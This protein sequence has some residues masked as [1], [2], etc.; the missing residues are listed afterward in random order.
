MDA[1]A[2]WGM[3]VLLAGAVALGA[4]RVGSLRTSGA[5][6]AFAI[7]ALALRAAWSWGAFLIGWFVL[8]SVL[9]RIGRARKTERTRRI[10]EKGDQRDAWQVLANGGVFAL[11]AFGAVVNSAA[12]PVLGA[13]LGEELRAYAPSMQTT[14]ATLAAGALIAAGADTW[15]TEVGTLWGGTPWSL[16]E[17][18][19]VPAGTSGAVSV[20]GTGGMLLGAVLLTALA[21]ATGLIAVDH[22]WPVAIGGVGGACVDTIIGAWIQER[23]QCPACESATERVIHDCG[24]P[25]ARVGGITRLDNDVV[26]ALCT[27]AGAGLAVI[28][29]R[30]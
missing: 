28:L 2:P 9:S 5:A 23:R 10:V 26:N 11:A 29:A 19:R 24:T 3:A 18:G 12:D 7:G 27:M 25:T 4:W 22:A 16:R 21:V 1:S 13:T 20:V 8:S 6:A 15:A 30:S 14:L 17:G